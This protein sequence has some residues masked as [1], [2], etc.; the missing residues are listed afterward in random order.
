MNMKVTVA[1]SFRTAR[2]S[3][4]LKATKRRI[5]V[6]NFICLSAI[7]FL[8]GINI[9]TLVYWRAKRKKIKEIYNYRKQQIEKEEND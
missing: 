9:Y 1:G 4:I 2:N 6:N 7:L 3:H 5:T 8:V